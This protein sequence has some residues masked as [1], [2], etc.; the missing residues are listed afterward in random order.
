VRAAAWGVL[1]CLTVLSA[2][3]AS[4]Q[5]RRGRARNTLERTAEI[6]IRTGYDFDSE[7]WA[8]G[9]QAR[10]P[11]TAVIEFIPSG[12]FYLVENGTSFQVNA[13]LAFPLAPRGALYGGAGAGF[14]VRDPGLP[15]V[16]TRTEFGLNLLAGLEPGRLRGSRIRWFV[17]ARW[18]VIEGNNPFRL[19]AGINF[20]LGG[21]GRR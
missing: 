2:T 8:L 3:Q 14:F 15:G 21:R 13:D 12:D 4:A 11:L 20:P 9:A 16:E 18:Y 6:G 10:F 7:D 5:A 1:A 17:E 19:A